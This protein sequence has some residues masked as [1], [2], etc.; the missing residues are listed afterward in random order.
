MEK[1]RLELNIDNKLSKRGNGN[2]EIAT[3]DKYIQNL[4]RGDARWLKR[5]GEN[6]GG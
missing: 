5:L 3:T 6:V 1:R 4:T 2:R